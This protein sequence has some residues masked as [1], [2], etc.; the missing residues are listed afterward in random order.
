MSLSQALATAMSGLRANQAALA[1]VSS[2]VANAET[3]G[4]VRKTLSQVQA[5]TADYG[6]SVRIDGVNRELDQF[7]QTQ[8]RTETSGAAYADIRA[9][10]LANLQGVYG[11]PDSSGT[12]ESALNT[13][14]TAVQALSTSPD[15]QSARIGVVNAAQ[16][17]AQQLNA[18]S[19]GIQSLRQSAESGLDNA[20][21]TAN[22][23]LQQIATINNQ[24][25]NGRQTDASTA[26]LLDQRDQYITQLSQLMDVRVV[27]NN[28]NQVSVFTNSGVQ[29][30]GVEAAQL[31][32][33]AQG[34]VTPNAQWNSD[35][36]KSSLGSITINFPQGGSMDLISSGAIRSGAIAAYIELRDDTLVQAQAQLD[37]LAASMSSALSD[38][39]TAGTA[40][41]PGPPDGYDLDLSGLQDGN[42]VH[43]TYKDNI[44]GVTH[45]LSIVRVDDPSV[46]PLSNA[47]T[48]DPNDEVLGI[49]FSGGM[50]SVISQLNTA[51][52]A[53]A[54]LQFSNPA[55]STLRVLDDGIGN[56]VDINAAS[57]TTT[58]LPTALAAGSPEVSL[59]TDGG[60]AYTGA[61]TAGGTQQTGLAARISINPYLLADPSKLTVFGASTASGDSTR[62]NFILNQLTSATLYYGPQTGIGTTAQPYKGSLMSFTQQ[63][64]S[65]Q[66]NAAAAAKQLADGQDVVLNT[67]QNK[68]NATSGVNIDDEMAH[69]LALQNAYSANARVMATV[70]DMY[71]ALLQA[72]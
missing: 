26:S 24:L 37:Q 22:N 12:L 21:T 53:S 9:S 66:G 49:D 42:V 11:D 62:A 20:V 3:P 52:T 48:V 29:L 8:L 36:S 64:L 44:T 47:A 1:L 43:L 13:L 33:N 60:T 38:K 46:L 69:L 32:F 6:S 57:V 35:P 51:L 31:S 15:S 68:M 5:T 18:T 72:M 27:T 67:L 4:Y 19:Q 28:L 14:T 54:G 58:A 30:V 71:A 45:N 41:P 10:F 55:G 61:I 7:L 2:N 25:V 56:R 65:T 59:F 16:M 40:L 34:T 50:A 17:L 23:A 70:K 39:T 63:I